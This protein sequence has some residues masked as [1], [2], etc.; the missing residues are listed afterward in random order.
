M[1]NTGWIGTLSA[2]VPP[3][4]SEENHQNCRL[5]IMAQDAVALR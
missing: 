5:M 3:K 2:G 1:S 4:N